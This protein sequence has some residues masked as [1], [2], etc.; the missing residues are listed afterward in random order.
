MV[1]IEEEILS[2][3]KLITYLES[4]GIVSKTFEHFPVFTVAE[5]E[6]VKKKIPGAHTKNLFLK[7]KKKEDYILVCMLGEDRLDL[8]ALTKCLGYGS[9]SL[10]FASDEKLMASLKLKP[11]HVTP[12]GLIYPSSKGIRVILDQDMMK[13]EIVNFHPLQN[14]KTTSIRS[15][16]LLK[17]LDKVGH[18]AEIMTLPKKI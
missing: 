1:S 9:G 11:G 13:H 3:E 14:N 4:L 7:V 12:F 15:E 6:E 16:D 2:S 10:S 8:K 17:F 18:S 5:G